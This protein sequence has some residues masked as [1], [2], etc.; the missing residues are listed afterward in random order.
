MN[1]ISE[2]RNRVSELEDK[3]NFQF[4]PTF[5]KWSDI[6]IM[7]ISGLT[8]IFN[9]K[10]NYLTLFEYKLTL[11]IQSSL[12]ILSKINHLHLNR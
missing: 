7:E 3:H 12:L 10:N 6:K 11:K 4:W 8:F 5:E 1:N 9:I 2:K